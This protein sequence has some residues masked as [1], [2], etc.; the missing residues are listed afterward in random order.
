MKK[1]IETDG[2]DALGANPFGGLSAKGLP[3]PAPGEPKEKP[4]PEKSKKRI[5][6]GRVELRRE[7]SGRGGKTVTTL[8][9]FATHLSRSQLEQLAFDL[10]KACACGGTRKERSIELQGD[11]RE[12]VFV[13]LE[14]RGY[15]PVRAGG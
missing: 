13:E 2:G 7:K 3:D 11:V 14:A 6:K 1:R 5:Q 8:S 9:A 10:K 4:G 15:Q 12:R